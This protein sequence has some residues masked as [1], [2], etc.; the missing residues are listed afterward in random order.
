MSQCS[1]AVKDMSSNPCV[2]ELGALTKKWKDPW[3]QVF[4]QDQ[5]TCEMMFVEANIRGRGTTVHVVFKY[6][7]RSL[8][9]HS[10]AQLIRGYF[11]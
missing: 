7:Y 3:G 11:I 9:H 2:A 1:V 4:L 6:L 8:H 10:A 5:E